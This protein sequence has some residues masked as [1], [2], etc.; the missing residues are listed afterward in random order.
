MLLLP[1]QTNP[2]VTLSSN[3]LPPGPRVLLDD[4]AD[5]R[6]D[7]RHY[8]SSRFGVYFDR[9]QGHYGPDQAPTGNRPTQSA[10]AIEYK[11][12][13]AWRGPAGKPSAASKVEE[14]LEATEC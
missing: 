1:A 13:P 7:T 10:K 11:Q 12:L 2:R 9:H 4:Q 5:T 3:S 6:R 14:L 8:G